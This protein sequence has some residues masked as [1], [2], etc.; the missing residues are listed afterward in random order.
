[1]Q[2]LKA[3]AGGEVWTCYLDGF[4]PKFDHAPFNPLAAIIQAK[5]AGF[6]AVRRGLIGNLDMDQSGR[7]EPAMQTGRQPKTDQQQAKQSG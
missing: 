7:F 3:S 2:I 5:S 1:M 4:L 6:V